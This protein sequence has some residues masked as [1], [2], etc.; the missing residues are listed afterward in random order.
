MT[1]GYDDRLTRPVAMQH[2][3]PKKGACEETR[4]E[5]CAGINNVST[6]FRKFCDDPGVE[7]AS[8]LRSSQ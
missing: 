1:T 4:N 3:M 5:Q 7:I 6:V 8:S 2:E